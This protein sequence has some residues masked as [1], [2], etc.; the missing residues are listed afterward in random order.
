MNRHKMT[1]SQVDKSPKKE[2]V[3]TMPKDINAL[4]N[5]IVLKEILDKP[6]ALRR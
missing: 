1:K 2:K 5:A 4:R 6:K 3:F